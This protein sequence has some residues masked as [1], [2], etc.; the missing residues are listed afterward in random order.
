M[1]AWWGLAGLAG[2]LGL[3]GLARIRGRRTRAPAEDPLAR[4]PAARE[5]AVPNADAA[6][7][8]LM[9]PAITPGMLATPAPSHRS[10]ARLI[11]CNIACRRGAL[12]RY[13]A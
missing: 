9:T 7:T 4:Y 11:A 2:L 1:T 6:H 13:I 10:N 8:P 3:F 12:A 5:P